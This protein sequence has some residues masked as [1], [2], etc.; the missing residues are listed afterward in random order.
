MLISG[1][2][3]K[4]VGCL[5]GWLIC[6]LISCVGPAN[7][8]LAQ[9]GA[10]FQFGFGKADVTPTKPLRLSG[11]GSRTEVSEGTDVPL[12]VRAMAIRHT[13]AGHDPTNYVLVSAESIGFNSKLT[14][15][16]FERV[17]KKHGL[18]REQFVVCS[19]HNHTSPHIGLGNL[20]AEEPSKEQVDDLNEYRIQMRDQTIAAIDA[21]VADLQTGEISN[22]VG[23]ATFARNRR[24]L[25]DGVWTG[26]G[27]T[28]GG[29]VDHSLPILKVTDST[30]E[31]IRGLIFNYACHCT[32]FGGEYNRV[33]GDWA[34][35]AMANLESTH[36]GV[37]A[38]CT[39]GCGAD[40]N[41][42]RESERALEL[43]KLQ[44]KEISSEV[45]RLLAEEELMPIGATGFDTNFGFAGLPIDR[46]TDSQLQEASED[47]IPQV[48]RHAME[49]MLTK[50]RMGRLPETYPMPI[51]VWRFG[52]DFAM[53]FL[54]GEVVADYAHR[55]RKELSE[56]SSIPAN[57]I[58]VTAYANDVF[59]YVPSEEMQSEGGYE[60]D[61]SQ[62]YYLQP[63]RWSK[64]TEEIVIDRVHDLFDG[65]A[66]DK[67]QAVD[68]SL[69]DF[70]L[71][72][73]MTIE[74][75]ATEPLIR[76]PINF[77][78]DAKGRMWVVEM[79]DYPKGNPIGSDDKLVGAERQYKDGTKPWDGEPGGCIKI[80]TDTDQ[81]GR[82]DQATI[83]QDNLT[84][85]TGVFPWR[86]GVIVSGAPDIYFARDTDG[87][88]KCDETQVLFTGFKKA[89]PQHR[90]NGFEYGL[91]GWLYLAS[92]THDN[93][94]ITS[95]ITGEKIETSGRDIR[96]QPDF[97][98][99]ET[100]SG[101]SQYGRCRD[102]NG[103]WFG[104]T[105]TEPL[106][107]FAIEERYLKRNPFVASPSPRE[108]L[109]AP[110][111]SPT[112]F[113]TSRTLDRFNDLDTLNKVTSACA[114]MVWND[115]ERKLGLVC[116]PV[117]NLVSAIE[118]E[119]NGVV[120]QGEMLN[121]WEP[122]VQHVARE[123]VASSDN[124]FRPV[125]L[126]HAPSEHSSDNSHIW[127][128]D[129]YR[130]VIE[131]PEW[132]PEAWQ[133]SLDLY[134][135]SNRGRVYCL[136]PKSSKLSP[137]PNF[138]KLS[139][140]ELVAQLESANRWR[141]DTAQRLLYERS[142]LDAEQKEE[143]VGVLKP[144]LNRNKDLEL[145]TQIF[146]TMHCVDSSDPAHPGNMIGHISSIGGIDAKLML[147]IIRANGL[148]KLL[149]ED[150]ST[151]FV[152]GMVSWK[153]PLL[154]ME[155]A[156]AMG[157]DSIDI[158]KRIK[159]LSHV[160]QTAEAGPW[161]NAAILSSS[162]GV[163]DS[164]LD[165]VF[166]SMPPSD[167]RNELADGLIATS[168][169]NDLRT[170]CAAIVK[171]LQLQQD[172]IEPWHVHALDS[173]LTTMRKKGIS[174]DELTNS[175]SGA[176]TGASINNAI[177]LARDLV[178]EGD[179]STFDR[180]AA[181]RLVGHSTDEKS[182]TA[183]ML[184]EY[185]Q[186]QN[187]P[188]VQ[189]A[190]LQS[191]GVLNEVGLVLENFSA[192]SPALQARI[193]SLL[194][195]QKSW[196][197]SLLTA[198]K[199]GDLSL[200]DLATSTRYDLSQSSHEEVLK[201]WQAVSENDSADSDRPAV[202]EGYREILMVQGDAELGRKV[203]ESQCANCHRVADIGVHVGPDVAGLK[204][205]T[206]EYFLTAILD[207]NRAIESKYRNYKISTVDGRFLS[208]MVLEESATSVKLAIADGQSVSVLR[209]EIDEMESSGVSFMP[210][211]FE[212][213][214]SKKQMADLLQ[215]VHPE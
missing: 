18:S 98:L 176:E 149:H 69:R 78:V 30:G 103:N 29:T 145:R 141:R 118:L 95:A 63:G 112:I 151:E 157:D 205:K 182:S 111:K 81:D 99:I 62:I 148:P 6:F 38:L 13:V 60:V 27:E 33:N 7:L 61:F 65:Q 85:P 214:I 53:V 1:V 23:K 168:I 137:A 22:A 87:D 173:L 140:K 126:M 80:L 74:A 189:F 198:V 26:F 28:P 48:R 21:A 127:I 177:R 152:E 52:Q 50:K 178:S 89:N 102:E 39:I 66:I 146:W 150:V 170:G 120:L 203:F 31:K 184:V 5:A 161:M 139:N 196:T 19:T 110:A 153:E 100:L 165:K 16:I 215:F 14:Q 209:S 76:D 124:W 144:S 119:P 11:Y 116:E 107:Q 175:E 143:I 72:E 164:L 199:D 37:T 206:K 163:A 54:G 68:Q 187:E 96:I 129:M 8:A 142:R 128:C 104:N 190:S 207:P 59:G 166:K 115:G 130:Q 138:E 4:L 174:I 79:G 183:E 113:P 58:W 47:R 24:V 10:E 185:M 162:V 15:A 191:L 121:Q 86:D 204:E 101:A 211:G 169:G 46:P 194:L 73:G 133:S 117:H 35:Y 213:S 45:D 36:D 70:S 186:P 51:Q 84:F 131:H 2:E 83:F 180:A 160:I 208:G 172:A 91:D 188:E 135:G 197:L 97:G 114:P 202:V 82:Y 32:T 201:A 136:M 108:F 134:A 193:Q 9:N 156:L 192:A 195:T 41:P 94:V 155:I 49:M 3:M 93:G 34:G 154:T 105:N 43:A 109:T 64:G 181:I 158:Q 123:F 55:I 57:R 40:S 159:V 44:G 71:A 90:I 92:G 88:D 212:K 171:S 210:E 167:F 77:C 147:Q 132:I 75:I 179:V 25:A 122:T 12:L 42:Q 106:F 67:P 200:R 125:R 17:R 20:F 56:K